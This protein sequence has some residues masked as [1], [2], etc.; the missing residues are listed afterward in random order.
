MCLQSQNLSQSTA[1]KFS[2]HSCLFSSVSSPIST[3]LKK[4]YFLVYL[5]VLGLSCGI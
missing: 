2:F 1:E 3:F 4:Y 5:V